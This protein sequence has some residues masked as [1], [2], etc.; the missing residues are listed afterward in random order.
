MTTHNEAKHTPGPWM[1]TSTGPVMQGYTQPFCIAQT[2]ANNLIAGVFGDVHGGVEIAKANA[3][4]E[5]KP[6]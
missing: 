3:A 1:Y 4:L 5:G 2:S 6:V